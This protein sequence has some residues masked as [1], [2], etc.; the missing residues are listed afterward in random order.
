M[1]SPEEIAD[2]WLHAFN[3]QNL[4]NLLELY[5]QDAVHF[6]PKL[7]VRRPESNGLIKGKHALRIWW[8]DAFDRLPELE[9]LPQTITGN[10]DRV[11]MEYLR[12]VP[13]EADMMVAE[14]LEIEEGV[15]VA[16]RVYHS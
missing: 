13:G 2:K 3:D 7:K 16:S 15:I 5:H 9:Y 6:S 8:Q 12:R 10:K 14:V 4:E 1:I 11:F